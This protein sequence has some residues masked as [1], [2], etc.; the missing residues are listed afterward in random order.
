MWNL[1]RFFRIHD[2]LQKIVPELLGLA[3]VAGDGGF[4][5]HAGDLVG[6]Q[7]LI[8]S[9]TAALARL[10]DHIAGGLGE[11]E[12]PDICIH[13]RDH[14]ALFFPVASEV[15][16]LVVPSSLEM[17]VTLRHEIQSLLC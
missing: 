4:L 15:F 5:L 7:R 2:A 13:C 6:D 10:A 11:C 9:T 12:Q 14:I 16:L 8:G 1:E 17:T 3:L